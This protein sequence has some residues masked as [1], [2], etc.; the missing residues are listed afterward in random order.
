VI[1]GAFGAHTFK[2]TLIANN[3]LDVFETA[4]RYQFYHTL[5][6]L[7]IGMLMY[8]NN[9]KWIKYSALALIFGT[10]LFSGSL[11]LLSLSGQSFWGAITP[12]GGVFLILGWS[13]LGLGIL[14]SSRS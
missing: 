13:F 9:T 7:F 8:R 6:L 2:E 1:L 11:Y 3:Y 12:L 14:N 4:V 10:L 5:V